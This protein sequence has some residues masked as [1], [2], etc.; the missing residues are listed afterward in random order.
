MPKVYLFDQDGVM[1]DFDGELRRQ[2][3]K[4]FPNLPLKPYEE[5]TKTE[6]SQNYEEPWRSMIKTIYIQK[7]FFLSL[8]PIPGSLE[9]LHELVDHGER[10]RICTAPLS[11]YKYCINEKYEWIDY[12]LGPK[13]IDMIIPAKDKTYVRGDYL[14]DDKPNITGDYLPV[15]EHILYDQPYNHYVADKRRLTWENWREVLGIK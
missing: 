10:V 14:I 12:W 11:Q 2:C 15:W 8:P 6:F 1:A 7:G 3:A 5:H 13:F 9:A 4:I